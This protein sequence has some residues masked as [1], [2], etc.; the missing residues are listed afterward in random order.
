MHEPQLEL[1]HFVSLVNSAPLTVVHMR[2]LLLF[3]HVIFIQRILG[4]SSN[5]ISSSS[6]LST[7]VCVS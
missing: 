1:P 3:C 6:I 7:S 5:V 4:G 2:F